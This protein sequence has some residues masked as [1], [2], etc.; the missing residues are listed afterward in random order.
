MKTLYNMVKPQMQ[1]HG[2]ATN[3]RRQLHQL[4]KQSAMLGALLPSGSIAPTEICLL[5]FGIGIDLPN[6]SANLV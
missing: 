5:N 6:S 4:A 1:I 2:A 3:Q